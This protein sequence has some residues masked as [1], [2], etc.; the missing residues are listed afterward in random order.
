MIALSVTAPTTRRRLPLLALFAANTVSLTGNALMFV[1][2]PWFVLATT[3]SA[4]RMGLAS[5][6]AAL[7][8]VIAAFFGGALVDRLGYRR[9]SVAGDLASCLAVAAIPLLSFT[10]GL[11][12]WQLLVLVFVA[13]LCDAPGI[14]ARRA[15]V[16]DLARAAGMPLERAGAIT[17]G[18]R[19]AAVLAGAPLAGLLITTTGA[20]T[21]LLIDAATFAV[22][23]ALVAAA[24]PA[25]PAA[26]PDGT[27]YLTRVMDG[28][29]FIRRS[30]LLLTLV[31]AVSFTNF[32]DAHFMIALPVYARETYGSATALGLLLAA[33][34]G[35]ALAG[36]VV[37][38]MLGA[39]LPRRPA[40][41]G[42]FIV[43]GLPIWLLLITPALPLAIASRVAGGVAAAP[44]D[45]VLDTVFGERVPDGLRGRVFGAISGIAM[46]TMPLGVLSGGLLVEVIGVLP[47]IALVAALFLA[48]T[49]AMVWLPRLRE[50]G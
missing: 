45:P 7:P 31:V 19:R 50:M 10:V 39:R 8:A 35:G 23:A 22:S 20:E 38:G 16:P 11:A 40:F 12:F 47:L 29:R 26:E 27:P 9:M 24:V 28:L 1:S 17:Q 2:V 48:A 36:A 33:N 13:A 44:L 4:A 3:G 21:V 42:G 6:C 37:V 15:L 34:G 14:T 43:A 41:V 32:L 5:F 25:T 46:V 49:L 18:V 30:P